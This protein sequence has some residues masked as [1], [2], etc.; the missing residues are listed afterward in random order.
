MLISWSP[1]GTG[2][3]SLRRLTV[4]AVQTTLLRYLAQP[5]VSHCK[6]SVRGGLPS[7]AVET[8]SVRKEHPRPRLLE[9]NGPEGSFNDR[10]IVRGHRVQAVYDPINLGFK[11]CRFLRR[12][13]CYASAYFMH[14]LV[15]RA[16][17][18]RV[19]VRRQ[20][21]CLDID[22]ENLREF[23]FRYLWRAMQVIEGCEARIK[24]S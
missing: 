9:P 8:S 14:N 15:Q 7:G 16:I 12:P 6:I 17:E 23:A 3:R 21:E 5:A 1:V 24:N 22:N 10:L 13:I 18:R 2:I 4:S 11:T 20:W 19:A